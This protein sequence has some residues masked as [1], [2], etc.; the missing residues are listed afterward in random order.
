MREHARWAFDVC[1]TEAVC[2]DRYREILETG[3]FSDVIAGLAELR[4]A[5]SAMSIAWRDTS[6]NR[7]LLRQQ[8]PR[9]RAAVRLYWSHWD[10][11]SS[12]RQNIKLGGRKLRKYCR[13]ERMKEG[14]SGRMAPWWR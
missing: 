2:R 10:S 11:C 7:A 13:G 1:A 12:N 3:S 14:V 8:T 9:N 4:P 6:D 5:L